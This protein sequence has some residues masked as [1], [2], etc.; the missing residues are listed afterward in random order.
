MSNGSSSRTEWHGVDL[1]KR[2]AHFIRIFIVHPDVADIKS[3]LESKEKISRLSGRSFGYLILGEPGAGKSTLCAKFHE[4]WPAHIGT[5]ITYQPVV[6]M[7]IPRPCTSANLVKELLNGLGDPDCDTGKEK[8]NRRRALHLLKECKTRFLVVDN[9]Q[10]VPERRGKPGVRVIGNWFRDLFDDLALIF[11][12]LG[13]HEAEEVT[14]FNNQ[15]KR[16]VMARRR[17]RYFE[18][19]TEEGRKRWLRLLLEI[20]KRLPLAEDSNLSMPHLASRLF[21]ATNGIFHYLNELILE[22][23]TL[24]VTAG[25]EQIAIDDLRM[26]HINLHGEVLEGA[27]PFDGNFVMR[28]LNRE[29]EPFYKSPPG[30]KQ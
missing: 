7:E 11:V 19:E 12:C 1:E 29:G 10:D 25:R 8:E 23:L 20:D 6:Q 26:G 16:R 14:L 15:V 2:L 5:E 9:F 3:V 24:S 13:T 17:L 28:Y 4:W 27:N 30:G 22:G 21:F 18:I